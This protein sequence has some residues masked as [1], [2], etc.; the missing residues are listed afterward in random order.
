MIRTRIAKCGLFER[1]FLELAGVTAQTLKRWNKYGVLKWVYSMLNLLAG[2]IKGC[3]GW[4]SYSNTIVD[5]DGNKYGL[6][7]IRALFYYRSIDK[8]CVFR[9]ETPSAINDSVICFD[10]NLIELISFN[11]EVS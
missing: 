8:F 9:R 10:D 1:E 6:N 11:N 3:P 4:R 7:E 2:N 5:P